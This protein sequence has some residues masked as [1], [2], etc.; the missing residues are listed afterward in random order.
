MLTIVHNSEVYYAERDKL[1]TLGQKH[2][3]RYMLYSDVKTHVLKE[4]APNSDVLRA[5]S[6]VDLVGVKL[7]AELEVTRV[8][9]HEATETDWVQVHHLYHLLGVDGAGVVTCVTTPS[10]LLADVASWIEQAEPVALLEGWGDFLR[11]YGS[12]LR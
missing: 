6:A 2:G 4:H 3:R 7:D 10:D 5:V 8:A 9:Y 12:E 11:R 1:V